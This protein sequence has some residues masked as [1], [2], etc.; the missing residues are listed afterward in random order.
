MA[1]NMATVIESAHAFGGAKAP[2]SD[3]SGSVEGKREECATLL[4]KLA[5]EGVSTYRDAGWCD[6]E[7][8]LSI[9]E[10]G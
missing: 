4:R 1:K 9:G 6:D 7:I 5:F 2:W 3:V 8:T 10:I